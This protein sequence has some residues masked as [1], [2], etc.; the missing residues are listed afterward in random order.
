MDELQ[1]RQTATMSIS[2]SYL[3]EL[4]GYFSL[5]RRGFLECKHE[6]RYLFDIRDCLEQIYISLKPYCTK[7]QQEHFDAKF[8]EM[9]VCMKEFSKGYFMAE[10]EDCHT[11]NFW[12]TRAKLLAFFSELT[13]LAV[14]LQFFPKRQEKRR[15]LT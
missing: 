5:A 10:Q 15:C 12:P 9:Q 6:M 1:N 4:G 11:P 2:D 14:D 3:T 7:E 8:K 13:N